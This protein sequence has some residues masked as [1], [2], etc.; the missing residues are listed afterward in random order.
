MTITRSSLHPQTL[1][2]NSLLNE[3]MVSVARRMALRFMALEKDAYELAL[4]TILR[5][6]LEATPGLD[7]RT[8][9]FLLFT[10]MREIALTSKNANTGVNA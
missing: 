5:A 8:L 6:K 9:Q 3:D 1:A 2:R 7:S 4:N 10:L